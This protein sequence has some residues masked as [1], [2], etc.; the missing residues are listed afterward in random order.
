MCGAAPAILAASLVVD[1]RYYPLCVAAV[2]FVLVGLIS[3]RLQIQNPGLGVIALILTAVAFPVHFGPNQGELS[4]PVLLAVGVCSSWLVGLILSRRGFSIRAFSPVGLGL[5]LLAAAF[6]SAAVGQFPVFAAAPAPLRAQVGGLLIFGLSIGL[7][8]CLSQGVRSVAEIRNMTWIFL[9]AG[10]FVLVM[11][12][13]Q[14]DAIAVK[15]IYPKTIGSAFWTWLVALSAGQALFNFRMRPL[16]R[17]ACM[18]LALAAI[19]DGII[20]R[21]DWASGWAPALVVMGV[22]VTLRF[23]GITLGAGLL[24]API[25]GYFLIPIVDR[26]LEVESYSLKSRM[27]AWETLWDVISASPVFGLGPSNY[28]HFTELFPTLGWYVKFSSHQQ[29]IDLVAQVGFFGFAIFLLF[30]AT[31]LHAL[32]RLRSKTPPGGFERAFVTSA[33]AG[34]I[35]CLASGMLADWLLPFVYN[36]GLKGFRSSLL[37]WAFLGLAMALHRMYATD[38]DARAAKPAVRPGMRRT[39]WGAD[40]AFPELGGAM[41]RARR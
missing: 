41:A 27:A 7:F 16:A 28:Y 10:L 6:W 39:R 5:A 36:I 9:F 4:L 25:V 15:T 30:M 32:W 34:A 17:A 3:A 31:L 13:P 22:L 21:G 35:G 20:L 37:F 1:P 14:L 11:Y 8:I 12:R 29:Y 19:A 23:P 33:L 24:S 40:S 38:E 18:L 2:V 26:V